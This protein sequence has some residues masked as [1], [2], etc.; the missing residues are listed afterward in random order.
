MTFRQQRNRGPGHYAQ[1]AVALLVW[2]A[3]AATATTARAAEHFVAAP[4]DITIVMSSIAQPG[5]TLIMREGVWH[6]ADILFSGNGTES[7]PITLR[8]EIPG[9]VL[10]T[11]TSRLRI[12]GNFL[13]VDGLKFVSGYVVSGDV[14]AFRNS[15]SSVANNCRV[16]NCAIIDYNP[17]DP[18]DD[19]KWVS[20]YGFSNRVDNCYFKGKNNVGSTLVVWVDSQ[21]DKPNYHRIEG[22]YFGPRIP[23]GL[24]GAE[25][26]RIGTSEVSMNLSR[27]TVERNY[28]EQCNGEAEIVSSKS[29]ENVFRHNTFV[30][31]E[32]AL[33][34]RHG[35]RCVVE[36]NYFFGNLKPQTGGVRIIGEDHQV[37]NNYFADLTGNGSRFALSISQ[38]LTNS[39]LS[40]YFQV[41]RALVAFNT[42]ANCQYNI[43]VGLASTLSGTT[44]VTT[45]PPVDCIVANNIV[46]ASTNA[47]KLVDQRIEPV[48]MLWQGNIMFGA[49]LGIPSNSGI[50]ELNPNLEFAPDGLW[51]PAPG[52]PALGTAAGS[53]PLYPR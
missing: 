1:A 42:F 23:L 52:S 34:L 47:T 15:S 32:G 29:C 13:V 49:G 2:L 17:D 27:T 41:K 39:P 24:N 6:D 10:L 21:P 40:G 4:S 25:T 46:R 19:T 48:N 38:G 16:S 12:A 43:V 31:C 30:E 22:N 14:I 37:F 26:I 44:N 20:L 9:E 33:T 51:R 5:D 8:A 45:L 7:A 35:N 28:F 50:R 11:G 53:Y 36:G 3:A 18:E